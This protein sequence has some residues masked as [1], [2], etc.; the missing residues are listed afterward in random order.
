M[1]L[2]S[3]CVCNQCLCVCFT[4]ETSK[5][6]S[7]WTC[8]QNTIWWCFADGQ[9]VAQQCTIYAGCHGS[10]YFILCPLGS[11][12][13]CV[14]PAISQ[15]EYFYKEMEGISL[16][17]DADLIDAV[18]ATCGWVAIKHSGQHMLFLYLSLMHK[19]GLQ[20][21]VCIG[22]YFL[23]FSSKSICCGHSKEPSQW[24]GS[25]EHPKHMF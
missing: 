19:T 24:D 11:A 18:L 20:I 2:F 6:G 16:P 22:N 3:L 25:F 12:S 17:E 14:A 5:S 23:N 15:I 21:R 9:M 8:Q 4:H 7:P 13:T 10:S 1:L